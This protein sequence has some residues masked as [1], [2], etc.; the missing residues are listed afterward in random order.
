MSAGCTKTEKQTT[1]N[2]AEVSV[3]PETA[4]SS[5]P[6]DSNVEDTVAPAAQEFTIYQ[7]DEDAQYLIPATVQGIKTPEGIIKTLI[8]RQILPEGTEISK[9]LFKANGEYISYED[10][11]ASEPEQKTAELDLSGAFLDAMK[12]AG[13]AGETMMM[14]CI[15]NSLAENFHLQSVLITANGEIIETGHCIY[16]EPIS[17]YE[18]LVK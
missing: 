17:F 4:Y 8:D 6:S 16:D 10:G 5:E 13:S 1:R 12:Q 7:P 11:L 15:V 3:L 9:I 14:G 2:I 18:D